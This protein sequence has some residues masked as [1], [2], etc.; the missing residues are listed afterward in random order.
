VVTPDFN[1]S[2]INSYERKFNADTEKTC[3]FSPLSELA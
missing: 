2:S 1:E 3:T